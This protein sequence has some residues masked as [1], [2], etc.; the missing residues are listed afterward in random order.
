MT[1]LNLLRLLVQNS[2]AEFH[3]E[4]ELLPPKVPLPDIHS[5]GGAG[6]QQCCFSSLLPCAVQLMSVCTLASK[7]KASFR[8]FE[9]ILVQ[10]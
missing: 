5:S 2:I 1:G 7:L 8:L 6:S 10:H 4:L 3:T 9:T